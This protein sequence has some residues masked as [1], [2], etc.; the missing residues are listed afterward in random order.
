MDKAI[1]SK[2]KDV[3]LDQLTEKRR[4]HTLRVMSEAKALAKRY[5]VD[6]EKAEFAAL[7]H[8]MARCKSSQETE[9]YIKAFGLDPRNNDSIELSHSKIA[10]ELLKRNWG[11]DDPDVLNAI[12]YHT[13][14]RPKMSELEKVIYLADAIEPGRQ[15]PGVERLRQLAREDLD[16][17]CLEAMDQTI[18]YVT[19]KG[20]KIDEDTIRARDAFLAKK[21]EQMNNK[22][23]ALK[24]AAVLSAKKAR[25]LV[26]IDVIGR[27]SFADYLIL[28]TGGSERQVGTLAS[29][30]ID[31]LAKEGIV[32]KN[33]E[34]KQNSGW[35]LL[36]Y[37][38]IIVNVFS[39][40]QRS[41][42]NIEKIWG[43]C[44]FLDI[45][46]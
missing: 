25:D 11:I 5:G 26:V 35:I 45:E 36:D 18:E 30:V 37:G 33:V 6:A 27:S 17:A 34:G 28:A 21:G 22:E 23:I 40:E 7:C 19:G 1:F 38:D 16:K 3:I 14:G 12:A 8:D 46:G 10:A 24:T 41:R 32:P 42:Y 9:A 44:C 20:Y 13:T 4:N 43:D 29:D 31:Q 2:L 15:Y 39:E